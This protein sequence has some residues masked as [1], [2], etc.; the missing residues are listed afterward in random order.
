MTFIS[1]DTCRGWLTVSN[2]CMKERPMNQM[3]DLFAVDGIGECKKC[4]PKF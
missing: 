4:F 3:V 2:V 1:C